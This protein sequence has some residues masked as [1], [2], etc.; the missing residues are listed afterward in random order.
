M[1]QVVGRKVSPGSVIAVSAMEAIGVAE[2]I[3]KYNSLPTTTRQIP[4]TVVRGNSNWLHNIVKKQRNE[5]WV[6]G[7]QV[8]DDFGSTYKYVWLTCIT[9]T[10]LT[11]ITCT[12]LTCIACTHIMY[13]TL[14]AEGQ[15]F[16]YYDCNGAL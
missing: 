7:T 2:A 11:F 14:V 5:F 1:G 16:H 3:Q 15:A 10:C 9:C 8:P 6:D 12:H 4:Y 13:A